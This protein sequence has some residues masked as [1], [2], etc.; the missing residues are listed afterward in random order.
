[1]SKKRRIFAWSPLRKL[2]TDAGAEIVSKEAVEILL[3]F[4]EDR[5][6]KL[7][8]SALEFAK[9]SKRKK[10]SKEDMSLAISMM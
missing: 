7:T 10:I 2:M 3:N 4:L 6:K 9:H 5:T 1:M 8:S